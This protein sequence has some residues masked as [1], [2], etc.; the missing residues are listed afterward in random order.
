MSV[1]ALPDITESGRNA[2]L[3]RASKP[4]HLA[5]GVAQGEVIVMAGPAQVE[6]PAARGREVDDRRAGAAGHLPSHDLAGAVEGGLNSERGKWPS[7]NHLGNPEDL[8]VPL[9][10]RGCVQR[11]VIGPENGDDIS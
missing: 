2:S 8:V 11:I 3:V 6:R 5:G 9:R 10:E 1:V 7:G 4:R